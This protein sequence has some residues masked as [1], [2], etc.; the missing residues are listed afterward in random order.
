MQFYER[1]AVFDTTFIRPVTFYVKPSVEMLMRYDC[2]IGKF[3]GISGS[4]QYT[5]P[6]FT[7]NANIQETVVMSSSF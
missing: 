1:L 3:I 6:P 4:V 5:Q 2:W 7:K